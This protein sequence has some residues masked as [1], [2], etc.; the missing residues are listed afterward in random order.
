[1]IVQINESKKTDILK[2]LSLSE[3]SEWSKIKTSKTFNSYLK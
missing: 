3:K 2:K 1:M